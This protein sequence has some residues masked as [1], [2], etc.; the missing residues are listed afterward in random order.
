MYVVYHAK[1]RQKSGFLSGC[2]RVAKTF[3][4]MYTFMFCV[5]SLQST[6]TQNG[7]FLPISEGGK[8][9]HAAKDR[10]QKRCIILYSVYG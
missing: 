7:Q 4:Y 3:S 1:E 5:K 8:P 10:Q 9:A 2:C 6:K